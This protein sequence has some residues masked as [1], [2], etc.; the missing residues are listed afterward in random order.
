MKRESAN[1]FMGGDDSSKNIN[2]FLQSN[3]EGIKFF[4]NNSALKNSLTKN[5]SVKFESDFASSVLDYK[6]AAEKIC[7]ENDIAAVSYPDYTDIN[8]VVVT[9]QNGG[10]YSIFNKSTAFSGS[11]G[12]SCSDPEGYARFGTG[13]ILPNLDLEVFSSTTTI[14][15]DERFDNDIELSNLFIIVEY[16]GYY[17]NASGNVV[18]GSLIP[19]RTF[20][21]FR[22]DPLGG[23]GTWCYPRS[24][25][26]NIRYR[27]PVLYSSYDTTRYALEL[28][29]FATV[30]ANTRLQVPHVS[31]HDFPSLSL[32]STQLGQLYPFFCFR[33]GFIGY[34]SITYVKYTP[35]IKCGR[36]DF[37]IR[38]SGLITRYENDKYI[39]NNHKLQ[40]GDIIEI[41]S[42]SNNGINNVTGTRYIQV[43]DSDS[44]LIY[45]DSQ[46]TKRIRQ[47]IKFAEFNCIGNVY[48]N[49]NQGWKYSKTIFS[50]TGR[51]GQ[52][53]GSQYL[54]ALDPEPYT[55]YN[56]STE[57]PLSK[58]F[59]SCKTYLDIFYKDYSRASIGTTPISFL[60]DQDIKSPIMPTRRI[61]SSL[62]CVWSSPNSFVNSYR[63]GCDIDIKTINNEVKFIVGESGPHSIFNTKYKYLPYNLPYGR[64][65]LMTLSRDFQNE[66]SVTNNA[67]NTYD[68]SSFDSS[69]P[70]LSLTT[71][72][73]PGA[74]SPFLFG[75]NQT[76]QSQASNP[77][78][79]FSPHNFT[80]IGF[81]ENNTSL[82]D[83]Y[84]N[85][86]WYGA[87]VAHR[88]IISQNDLSDDF[89]FPLLNSYS[90]DSFDP[91]AGF[92]YS[93]NNP[94]FPAR[95]PFLDSF[96][97]SVA[98][99]ESSSRVIIACASTNKTILAPIEDREG[100]SLILTNVPTYD[101]MT[102]FNAP[103]GDIDYGYVHIINVTNS[104]KIGKLKKQQNHQTFSDSYYC[105]SY[106][107]ERFAK[108]IK[109]L[110]NDLY[111]G[112]TMSPDL[113]NLSVL[114]V[115]NLDTPRIN[116]Y[117]VSPGSYSYLYSIN[118]P[119]EIISIQNGSEGYSVH[120]K[121]IEIKEFERLPNEYFKIHPNR[122]IYLSNRFG[123][124]FQLNNNILA[125]NSYSALNTYDTPLTSIAPVNKQII[126]FFYI[127][128]LQL[129]IRLYEFGNSNPVVNLVE[130]IE[131]PNRP[132]YYYVQLSGVPI[133]NYQMELVMDLSQIYIVAIDEINITSPR[134]IFYPQELIDGTSNNTGD[135]SFPEVIEDNETITPGT[136]ESLSDYIYVYNKLGN[137]NY[138]IKLSPS[139]NKSLG[140]YDYENTIGLDFPASLK[141]YGN[142]TYDNTPNNSI[143]WDTDLT[144]S[145]LVVDNYILLKDPIGYAIFDSLS[146]YNC[147]FSFVG[148]LS[149]LKKSENE[150]INY[151]NP[152]IAYGS[153]NLP[154]FDTP[155]ELTSSWAFLGS[156]TN[157]S[158]DGEIINLFS[159]DYA[160]SLDLAKND[161]FSLFMV[162][163]TTIGGGGGDPENPGDPGDGSTILNLSMSS[164]ALIQD[165]ATLY[166]NANISETG[167]I[168]IYMGPATMK[169]N[170]NLRM[171]VSNIV[172]PATGNTNIFLS[173]EDRANIDLFLQMPEY[174]DCSLYCLGPIPEFN[175]QDLFLKTPEPTE[176]L[177][178]INIRGGNINDFSAEIFL[179]N[180]PDNLRRAVL[181]L[182]IG[183]DPE[184]VSEVADLFVRGS[185]NAGTVYDESSLEVFI[186]TGSLGE[187]ENMPITVFSTSSG[188][189]DNSL[190]L[191][192]HNEFESGSLSDNMILSIPTTS[193]SSVFYSGISRARN[194]TIKGSNIESGD[195][196][197]FLK[198]TGEGG[199]DESVN[200]TTFYIHNNNTSSG[201]TIIIDGVNGVFE[202]MNISIPKT[203]GLL[204]KNVNQF[205]RGYEE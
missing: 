77:T 83:P 143:T 37:Y 156:E 134:G 141:P 193:G 127:A 72:Q 52:N 86:Y 200:Y 80:E 76:S 53:L 47:D 14:D 85:D 96:G 133:N 199:G 35:V 205:I 21:A 18:L 27:Y 63:F 25:G 185:V 152:V 54:Q 65:H 100:S 164:R 41:A 5:K 110:N 39:C 166:Q 170:I 108:C 180:Y 50:P 153:S 109:F 192:I 195:T 136:P 93:I 183:R 31:E 119:R 150:R 57:I 179:E 32:F 169:G 181:P 142:K 20:E 111:V 114:F 82:K 84:F 149:I 59:A 10:L 160:T 13:L 58:D 29:S 173:N 189:S 60:R 191:K 89:I 17:T 101:F 158:D 81:D 176:D 19:D 40:N 33:Y 187:Q 66:A 126:D 112:D 88:G 24:I 128:G 147:V 44:I 145:Y 79:F 139:I 107:S 117:S 186:N 103:Y 157:Y 116:V 165:Q 163:S 28:E 38:K 171:I 198:R 90:S 113:T 162:V 62:D 61:S 23:P 26:E 194:I 49:S 78:I 4:Q 140:I 188:Q 177:V 55:L 178:P 154:Y 201:V 202:N 69:I 148:S 51:N 146:N 75:V 155:K 1:L 7:I 184:I 67:Q 138:T 197:L 95:Y 132:G 172:P 168:P 22:Y 175:N 74:L 45:E 73:S 68:A 56:S 34:K 92:I 46:M 87:L 104:T 43:V 94:I 36:V 106:A 120:E 122:K 196:T 91:S 182:F 131:R 15:L 203:T 9:N 99:G 161:I 118:R 125:A 71:G 102:P 64:C 30:M 159:F 123:E 174:N 167:I 3:I 144:D 190:P 70:K 16:D 204:T 135:G 121:E 8:K 6:W 42:V 12:T 98:I 129:K 11:G 130:C 115:P 48:D 105:Q 137:W 2:M 124:N 97:K 151:T